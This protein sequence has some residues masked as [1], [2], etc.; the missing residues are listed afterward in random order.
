MAQ[1]S[2]GYSSYPAYVQYVI[3]CWI[4]QTDS[5]NNRSLVS[6]NAYVYVTGSSA[7]SSGG[8]GNVYVNGTLTADGSIGY[9]SLGR[10]GTVGVSSG[11]I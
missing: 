7:S 11:S 8:S 3:D 2:G 6:V 1:A 9:W 5:A 10:Y 4:A